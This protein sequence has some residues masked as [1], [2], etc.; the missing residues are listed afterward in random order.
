MCGGG[1]RDSGEGG[2]VAMFWMPLESL[3]SSH[4]LTGKT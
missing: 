2:E 4:S 1:I 3:I